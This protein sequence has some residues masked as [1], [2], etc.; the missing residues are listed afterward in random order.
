[1]KHFL[2]M[3]PT[4]YLLEN[5]IQVQVLTFFGLRKPRARRLKLLRNERL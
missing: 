4:N 2:A 5:S 1:M 3:T